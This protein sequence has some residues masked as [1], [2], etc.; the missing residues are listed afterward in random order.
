MTSFSM[1]KKKI[2]YEFLPDLLA[3]IRQQ[4]AATGK[5][6]FYLE[7]FVGMGSVLRAVVPHLKVKAFAACDADPGLIDFWDHLKG[8]WKPPQK[9]SFKKYQQLRATRKNQTPL[10]TF[11]GHSCGFHSVYFRGL[12]PEERVAKMIPRNYATVQK[13]VDILKPK[14]DK[15]MFFNVNFFEIDTPQ[16][17]IIYLD[18]PYKGST[19]KGAGAGFDSAKFWKQASLWAEPKYRNIVVVSEARAPKEWKPIWQKE[20]THGHNGRQYTRTEYLFVSK[21]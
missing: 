21:K 9:I 11:V 6:H 3:H 20:H 4:E 16:D 13:V 1:G 14:W 5:K 10:H 7:P 8:G 12:C 18:P 19:D 17:T 2:S 15:I